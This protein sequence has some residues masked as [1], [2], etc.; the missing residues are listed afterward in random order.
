M[1]FKTK[2]SSQL[3][4]LKLASCESQPLIFPEQGHRK[5]S[6]NNPT[7]KSRLS[8]Y[9]TIELRTNKLRFQRTR[10]T[11]KTE[12]RELKTHQ[13]DRRDIISLKQ[14]PEKHFSKSTQRPDDE[15]CLL[16]I[17]MHQL[18]AEKTSTLLNWPQFSRLALQEKSNRTCSTANRPKGKSPPK[19]HKR[20]KSYQKKS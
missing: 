5:S 4:G 14:V 16:P 12:F 3:R 2:I 18:V 11:I 1:W 10:K 20:K 13:N 9:F 17:A 6:S 8:Y 15:V 19:S 7:A